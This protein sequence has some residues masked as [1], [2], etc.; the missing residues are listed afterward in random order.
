M[1]LRHRRSSRNILWL[2]HRYMKNETYLAS[3][4]A[5][6]LP[7][8]F[9]DKDARVPRFPAA[10][11]FAN[12]RGG[13]SGILSSP[14]VPTLCIQQNATNRSPYRHLG[15]ITSGTVVTENPLI[16]PYRPDCSMD[17]MDS[18]S[19]SSPQTFL[20][21]QP[22]NQRY[23]PSLRTLRSHTNGT[24][25][26][27]ATSVFVAQSF[28]IL[29]MEGLPPD[30]FSSFVTPVYSSTARLA[31]RRFPRLPTTKRPATG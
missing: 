10:T 12:E 25:R 29:R 27:S 9:P 28:G 7:I 26:G 15:S 8:K 19:S 24:R 13:E 4:T 2:H 1:P 22:K 5:H 3:Q 14:L 16:N 6:K 31:G 30:L 21:H 18:I 11:G 17:G 20:P 23:C